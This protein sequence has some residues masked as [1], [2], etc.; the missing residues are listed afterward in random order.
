MAVSAGDTNA[1]VLVQNSTFVSGADSV[2]YKSSEVGTLTATSNTIS[3]SDFTGGI[4]DSASS[5]I[6][7]TP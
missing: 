4:V 5:T 6:N 3:V 2:F 1:N 7:Y